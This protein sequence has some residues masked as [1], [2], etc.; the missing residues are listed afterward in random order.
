MPRRAEVGFAAHLQP[1][2]HLR[3]KIQI[4]QSSVARLLSPLTDG[5]QLRVLSAG[6]KIPRLLKRPPQPQRTQIILPPLQQH[7][8][9]LFS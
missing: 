3:L 5:L 9:Q 6:E 8:R 7:R 1:D 4:A 2:F